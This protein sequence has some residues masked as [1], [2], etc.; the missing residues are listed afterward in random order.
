M[1]KSCNDRI[2]KTAPCCVLRMRHHSLP[3][4]SHLWGGLGRGAAAG[5]AALLLVSFRRTTSLAIAPL[6]SP[7][8][9]CASVVPLLPFEIL[10]QLCGLVARLGFEREGFSVT[11]VSSCSKTRARTR[12]EREAAPRAIASNPALVLQ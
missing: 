8:C 11:S 3:A 4:P 5:H 10:N 9:L 6:P 1:T 12:F 7:L 2:M